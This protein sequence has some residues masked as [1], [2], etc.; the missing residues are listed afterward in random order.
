MVVSVGAERYARPRVVG[1]ETSSS[2][3]ASST[4]TQGIARKR[5]NGRSAKYDDIAAWV[6][7]ATQRLTGD[8]ARNARGR[9]AGAG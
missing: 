4:S 1:M 8:H 7:P 5:L 2:C 6:V 3:S 9:R